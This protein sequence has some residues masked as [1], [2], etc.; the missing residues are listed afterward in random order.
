MSSPSEKE[1]ALNIA[2][3][4]RRAAAA[5]PNSP[6]VDDGSTSYTHR[7][8]VA[9]GERLA[10]ALD[11]AGLPAGAAI[12]VLSDNRSEFVQADTA[13]ALGGWVRVAL[14]ARLHL[15]DF[16]FVAEDAELR[17]LFYSASHAEEAETLA[18]EF[19]LLLICLDE[20]DGVLTLEN[21][22]ATGN[23]ATR[24]R[25]VA[26]EAP[27]WITYTSGTTGRPKGIVLSHRAIREVAY[28]LLL[29]LSPVLPGEQIVLT[30]AISHASGYLILPYLLS[31]AGVYLMPKFDPA[32][33]WALSRRPN[34]RTL[35]AVPSMLEPLLAAD[36]GGEFGYDTIVYGASSIPQPVLERSLDRFGPILIQDYGQSEA[37]MTITCLSKLDH[38][39]AEARLSAGR[40]WRTVAV[41]VRGEDGSPVAVGDVGE[42]FVQGP[43]MMT[44]YHR[45]PEATADVLVDGWLR[46][47]DLAKVDD[48]GFVYLHGRNDEMIN[49]G[50]YNI[51]PREVEDVLVTFAGVGEVVV[52]GMPDP[53]WGDSVTA[54]I[55]PSGDSQLSISELMAFAR[56]RL[57]MRAP[58]RIEVW[59][60][61]PRTTYG[62]VD[63]I[64]VRNR[65]DAGEQS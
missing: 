4:L 3:L 18:K 63:R 2:Y 9:R 16:R 11:A 37:P 38:L 14:N 50:G 49:S 41:E 28:N 33:A 35:K 48:L 65:L 55:R 61:I 43:H 29:E 1:T 62:K 21:L 34:I 20:V 19:D 8:L 42:V 7:E 45:N 39:S 31:G 5:Y 58:K 44:R 22:V 60:E 32:E 40:P 53:R 47:K 56:P 30:Q 10:N 17:A 52:L 26:D 15:E 64:K 59:S 54:V 57:G 6:A 24:I 36:A 51:S 23:G 46:T 13:I 25:P 27:A 12:G